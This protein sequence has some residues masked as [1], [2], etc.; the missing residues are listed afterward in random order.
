MDID[1][2]AVM[3]FPLH[4]RFMCEGVDVDY[5]YWWLSGIQSNIRTEMEQITKVIYL[6]TFTFP[7][8]DV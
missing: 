1:D 6:W 2:A 3:E 5:S 8:S 7:E 4:N